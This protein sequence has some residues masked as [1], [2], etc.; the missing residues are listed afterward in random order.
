MLR[1]SV[2]YVDCCL[3]YLLMLVYFLGVVSICFALDG[4]LLL[5]GFVWVMVAVYLCLYG[6]EFVCLDVCFVYGLSLV[7]FLNELLVLLGLIC[8]GLGFEMLREDAWIM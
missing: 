2:V 7:N 4:G 8:L 1:T 3:H 5:L 6:W